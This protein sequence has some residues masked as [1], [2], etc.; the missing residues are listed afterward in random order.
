MGPSQ[1]TDSKHSLAGI[2]VFTGLPAASLDR[3]ERRC[4]WRRY[5]PGEPVVGYMDGSDDVFFL[6]LGEVRVT[7]YSSAGKA[8]SF[9]E[10]GTGEMFG[11]FPAID[12]GP[13]SASVEARTNCLIA[14]MTGQA[15]REVLE[16]EPG[17]AKAL[18]PRL[19]KTIRSLTTRIYEF[20]T[21]AV[22]NRIHA[23]LLRLGGLGPRQGKAARI[24][25]A[26]T[27]VEIASRVSTHRE[28]V[29]RELNRLA[30]IG[31]VE[32]RG[33]TLVVKDMD[34]LAEMVH[35]ATGE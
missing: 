22:N 21:L 3:I 27:H 6:A 24:V 8:V 23:E 35:E 17:V 30:K 1:T 20:S 2:A 19:V 33:G 14:S 9:R 25:P 12:R 4:A 5:Q 7:I 32:K 28:A 34:R 26:P 16:S 13:R 10:L 18:L 31:I 15:F 29:T 11:E